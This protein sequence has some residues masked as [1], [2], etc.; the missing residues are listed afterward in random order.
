[1]RD[2]I[3]DFD[4]MVSKMNTVRLT[5]DTVSLTELPDNFEPDTSEA[6]FIARAIP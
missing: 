1:M 6:D 5:Q 3:N 4:R 2:P